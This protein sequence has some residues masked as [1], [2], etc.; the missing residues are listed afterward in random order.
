MEYDVSVKDM[1]GL[2]M[3][4]LADQGQ[5]SEGVYITV[6]THRTDQLCWQSSSL[7]DGHRVRGRRGGV[8][9]RGK[10]CKGGGLFITVSECMKAR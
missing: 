8:R 10:T 5:L 3:Y 6:D 2:V 4:G 7:L 9:G 1:L